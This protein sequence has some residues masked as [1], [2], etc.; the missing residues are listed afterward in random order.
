MTH[1]TKLFLY[2]DTLFVLCGRRI[3]ARP[4][5]IIK[6]Q[7]LNHYSDESS[8]HEK[9]CT[10]VTRPLKEAVKRPSRLTFHPE[11]AVTQIGCQGAYVESGDGSGSG[12]NPI[13]SQIFTLCNRFR[14]RHVAFQ[15][16]R[17]A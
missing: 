9:V 14:L 11:E 15:T 10:K 6:R 2:T 12:V 3:T 8:V 4:R 16:A 13:V 17:R 1:C 7:I 5:R